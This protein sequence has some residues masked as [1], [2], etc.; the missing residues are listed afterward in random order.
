MYLSYNIKSNL[1]FI[2]K[3][4]FMNDPL[5]LT[6]NKETQFAKNIGTNCIGVIV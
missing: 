5:T 3:Q 1:H 4:L 6:S 2:L